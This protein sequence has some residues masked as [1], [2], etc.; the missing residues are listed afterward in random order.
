MNDDC[1]S[2][3]VYIIILFAETGDNTLCRSEIGARLIKSCTQKMNRSLRTENLCLHHLC[4]WGKGFTI[5]KSL[6]KDFDKTKLHCS[7][8]TPD[9]ERQLTL[10]LEHI[11][12]T[13]TGS[14]QTHKYCIVTRHNLP[15]SCFPDLIYPIF[16]II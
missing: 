2:G 6:G 3:C 15:N 14:C 8:R 13:K 16:R 5:F 9:T 10:I 7:V 4:A 1:V 12:I 11:K